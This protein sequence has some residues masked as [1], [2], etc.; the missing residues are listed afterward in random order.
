MVSSFDRT[1]HDKE[2]IMEPVPVVLYLYQI[3]SLWI[4]P[5]EGRI[6]S[7]KSF[8]IVENIIAATRLVIMKHNSPLYL[9]K[10]ARWIGCTR[11][12]IRIL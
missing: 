12:V 5:L 3:V 11:Q 1:N 6:V 10:G 7:A 2:N 8:R 4:Y 9:P